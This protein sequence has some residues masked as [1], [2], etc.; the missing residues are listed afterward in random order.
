MILLTKKFVHVAVPVGFASMGW[1]PVFCGV[2][3]ASAVPVCGVT[4]GSVGWET[5]NAYVPQYQGHEFLSPFVWDLLTNF[6]WLVLKKTPRDLI[7]SS[8]S[9]QNGWTWSSRLLIC[10]KTPSSISHSFV[11]FVGFLDSHLSNKTQVVKTPNRWKKVSLYKP[12]LPELL[13]SWEKH[14]NPFLF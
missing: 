6:I 4:S 3:F 1:L 9:R 13:K 5:S 2:T 11:F 10:Q 7:C 14:E 8:F 12:T